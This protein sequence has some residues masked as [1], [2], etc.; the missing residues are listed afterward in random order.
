MISPTSLKR[1]RVESAFNSAYR[2][3]LSLAYPILCK[4]ERTLRVRSH[5]ALVAVWHGEKL[6]VVRH[7]YRLG[8]ALPGGTIR[9]GEAPVEA[10]ARE[11]CEEV[12]I[13]ARPGDLVLLRRWSQKEG[14]RWL[15]EFRPPKLPDVVLDERE[16]I[17]AQF[18]TRSRIPA[19]I[20]AMLEQPA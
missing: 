6:L 11:L 18:V 16:V 19:P 7:S 14:K 20:R 13:L 2:F 5:V 9:V 8:D 1:G 15:F 4:I 10:A 17:R 3:V 12:G